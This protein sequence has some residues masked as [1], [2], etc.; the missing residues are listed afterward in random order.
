MSYQCRVGNF[1]SF[2]I[3]LIDFFSN[4]HASAYSPARSD[5]QPLLQRTYL[6]TKNYLA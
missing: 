5:L 6:F 3:Y 1:F 2:V 4:L